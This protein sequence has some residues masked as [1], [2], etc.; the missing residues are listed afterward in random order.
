MCHYHNRYAECHDNMQGEEHMH[1]LE[2]AC[3]ANTLICNP[4]A[5]KEIRN[6]V[7]VVY[8]KTLSLCFVVEHSSK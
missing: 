1:W 5:T 3:N 4:V 8:S 7:Q 2:T 6:G